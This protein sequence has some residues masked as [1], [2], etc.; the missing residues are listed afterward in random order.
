MS[1]TIFNE[2][3]FAF[4]ERRIDQLIPLNRFDYV[5]EKG[6]ERGKSPRDAEWRTKSY[7]SAA[8]TNAIESGNNLG[9][10]LS[11]RDLVV[12]MDP[13][14]M[15]M[16]LD[17]A[18][19]IL[20]DDYGMAMDTAP[21]VT[22]GS[23]G[24]H[25]Y[26]T[27]P[28]SWVGVRLLNEMETLPGVEFKGIGRQV[29]A[30][31]S[32]HPNG[33][34]YTPW[35]GRS[36]ASIPQA[37]PIL[38]TALRKPEIDPSK[39]QR[40]IQPDQ[41]A[42]MLSKLDPKDYSD[43]DKWLKLLMSCHAATGGLGVDEFI[44]WS[45]QD[46]YYIDDSEVIREK[47]DSLKGEGITAGTLF[48]EVIDAGH[49]DLIRERP[50]SA[51]EAGFTQADLEQ[52]RTAAEAAQKQSSTR[53]VFDVAR[54]GK[55]KRTVDNVKLAIEALGITCRRNQLTST[56]FI[57]GDLS[58]LTHYY[59][60]ASGQVD[61]DLL[62]G[63]RAAI[64][65]NYRFEPT[66]NQVAEAVSAL[67]ILRPYHPIREY[68]DDLEWDGIDRITGF[69][70]TYCGARHSP[71]TAGVAE[72]FFKAAV[73]RVMRPG[74]KFDTMVVLEGTQGCGKS[75]LVQILGGQW[76]L[77]GLPNKNDLNH[78]D[79]I[80]AIQ[81]HWT[82]E[83][84]ELAAMR[85]TDVD[86]MK[87]FLSRTSDKARFAYAR[88][89]KEYPRQCV[90]IGTTNDAQYLLDSTGNRRFLPIAVEHI[91]LQALRDD[92]DQIWAQAVQMWKVKPTP[93]A[94]MLPESLWTSA[95]Q[96]QSLRRLEDPLESK[97]RNVIANAEREG[98]TFLSTDDLME[99]VFSKLPGQGDTNDV[100]RLG[101][102]IQAISDDTPWRNGRKQ[103][104]EV[105]LKGIEKRD[106]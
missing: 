31:G 29:V 75:T 28:E 9:F 12:D 6:K 13:R 36:L 59:P 26:F 37:S 88:E 85:K 10:R 52:L 68:F 62:H 57:E 90:F 21:A 66:L 58:V 17:E 103:I 47:W 92:R 55:P 46:E 83:V 86:S 70:T 105:M 2:E 45:I 43:Y 8:I 91:H 14:N 18:T 35:E 60:D 96:E 44:E 7:S 40:E 79:V 11:Q 67:A 48:K 99:R 69:F 94:L 82:V 101:R 38:L 25:F 71:Y 72:V 41:L 73:G 78:K 49:G 80:Q 53:A 39:V 95:R 24:L 4:Y 100:R 87:A 1:K 97:L 5:D 65:S 81:G 98:E 42:E 106:G 30:A 56:N 74:I 23:G 84:E 15:V 89:A 32:R 104:G 3:C 63:I 27:I 76:A 34:P 22:T 33:N 51:F 50:D 64:T 16:S 20:I 93:Q 77:E 19:K 61:D 54:D 102:A